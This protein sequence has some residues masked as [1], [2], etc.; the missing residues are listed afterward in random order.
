ML[1]SV[2]CSLQQPI[3]HLGNSTYQPY[4]GTQSN[5]ILRYGAGTFCN[6][7]WDQKARCLAKDVFEGKERSLRVLIGDRYRNRVRMEQQHTGSNIFQS[8]FIHCILP[9]CVI[10]WHQDAAGTAETSL[11]APNDA[12]G[13]SLLIHV[14]KGSHGI[15]SFMIPASTSTSTSPHHDSHQYKTTN[16]LGSFPGSLSHFLFNLQL[17]ST[18]NGS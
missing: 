17:S 8:T 14:E 11:L 12:L 1:V 10:D 15:P 5:G 16:H 6:I 9:K 4:T 7:D 3:H 2:T 13:F 18:S